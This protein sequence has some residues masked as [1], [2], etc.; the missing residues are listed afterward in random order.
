MTEKQKTLVVL[1]PAF[2]KDETETNWV[3]SQQLLIKAL[4]KNFP[5]LPII[6]IAFLYPDRA[7]TY[8]WKGVKVISFNGMQERRFRRLL[9][10]KKIWNTLNEIRRKNGIGSILSFWCGECALIGT[11][12]GRFHSIKHY[13]WLCGQD[14]RSNNKMVR[15]IRPRPDELIAMSPFLIKEFYRNHGIR[16]RHLIINGIDPQLYPVSSSGQRDIDIMGAGSLIPL[17]QYDLFVEAVASL[18]KNMPLLHTLHC[19][20]G[21]EKYALQR[22]AEKK[23]LKNS[24][25]F[26]GEQPHEKV[27]QLMQRTKVFLHPSAY[28]GYS[29]TCLEALYAGAHVIS[30]CDPAGEKIPHW[31]VVQNTDEM[32]RCAHSI[33]AHPEIDHTPVL[34]QTMD[35]SAKAVMQ[36][37]RDQFPDTGKKADG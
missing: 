8:R 30:F 11:Y 13:C 32:I 4:R 14:A 35:E 21:P 37:L 26:A 36:L 24:L 7:T 27:L 23:G 3:P 28:E 9:L 25:C 31:H 12:F 22:L 6:V 18:S 33:L 29:T 2:P 17:K 1:S 34:V 20:D 16:P 19:G 5:E 15:I 10:W